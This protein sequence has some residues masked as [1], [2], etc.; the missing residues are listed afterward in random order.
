MPDGNRAA[1]RQL[2]R[3]ILF[4]FRNDPMTRGTMVAALARRM[5]AAA[6]AIASVFLN[7]AQAHEK[8]STPMLT[9][10]RLAVLILLASA[11]L[12]SASRAE[13]PV[14]AIPR[15]AGSIRFHVQASIALDGSFD[16]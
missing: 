10:T 7:G 14:F 9:A 2:N 12:P 13:A 1:G 8:A 16:K 6:L 3:D 5:S 15:D 11:L 4:R